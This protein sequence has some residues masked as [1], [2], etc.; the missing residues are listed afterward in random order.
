MRRSFISVT[1]TP[2]VDAD[3]TQILIQTIEDTLTLLR[4]HFGRP[5]Q[6]DPTPVVRLFGAWTIPTAPHRAVYSDVQWYVER[7]LDESG[8]YLVASRYLETIRLEPWQSSSP[9]LDLALTE[10]PIIDDVTG[11]QPLMD[12]LGFAR[13]GLLSLVSTHPFLSI[14]DRHLRRVAMWQTFAHYFGRLFDVPRVSRQRDVLEHQGGLY[15]TN[16]C[17]LRFTDTPTLALSFG[18]QEVSGGV[19][20]CE[21]CQHDLAAQMTGF[22]YGMN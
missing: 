21:A 17:A 12:A 22:H 6:F 16:T 11:P 5:G 20:Y 2:G 7:C 9:H 18:Q 14:E 19:I 8:Q 15:C 3:S 13:P 1:W 10:L 4:R